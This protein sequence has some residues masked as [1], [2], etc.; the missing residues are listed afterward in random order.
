MNQKITLTINQDNHTI[1]SPIAAYLRIVIH[2]WYFFSSPAEVTIKNQAY[3][4][5]AT[6]IVA[7]IQS[8]QLIVLLIVSSN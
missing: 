1:A 2:F 6:A 5:I 3:K 8:N 4:Q 7:S